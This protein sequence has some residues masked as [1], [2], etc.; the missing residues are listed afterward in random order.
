MGVAAQL[1]TGTTVCICQTERG[2][3][4]RGVHAAMDWALKISGHDILMDDVIGYWHRA[5][6]VKSVCCP[7]PVKRGFL[8]FSVYHMGILYVHTLAENRTVLLVKM[9]HVSYLT[10]C[11]N[12]F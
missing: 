5:D 10:V 8:E 2:G 7:M 4:G 3:G 12:L 11:V 1:C 9:P 6:N